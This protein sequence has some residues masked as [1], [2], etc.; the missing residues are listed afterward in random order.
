M[1]AE[2]K[3]LIENELKSVYAADEGSIRNIK[4]NSDLGVHI[5]HNVVKKLDLAFVSKKD[6]EEAMKIEYDKGYYNGTKVGGD[7]F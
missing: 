2:I 5:I 3:K 7:P 4:L 1:K 6:H